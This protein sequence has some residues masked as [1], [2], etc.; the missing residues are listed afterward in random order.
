[1][2]KTKQGGLISLAVVLVVLL[3]LVL[4]PATVVA[5]DGV[6]DRLEDLLERRGGGAPWE[7]EFGKGFGNGVGGGENIAVTGAAQALWCEEVSGDAELKAAPWRDMDGDGLA[8]V[9][10]NTRE[11]L[12]GG[13]YRLTFIAKKGSSG[14]PLWQESHTGPMMEGYA[15]PGADLDGDGGEDVLVNIWEDVGGVNYKTTVIAKNGS[16]GEHLWQENITNAMWG[17]LAFPAGDLDGD[18]K[19]DVMVQYAEDIGGG[20]VKCT[21]IAKRGYDGHHFW[22]EDITGPT[23]VTGMAAYPPKANLDGDGGDDVLVVVAAGINKTLIAKKDFDGHHLWQETFAADSLQMSPWQYTYDLNGDGRPDVVIYGKDVAGNY[24]LAAINGGTGVHL[25]DKTFTGPIDGLHSSRANDL[26]GDGVMD[27]HVI[28]KPT[29]GEFVVKTFSG[30]T[31]Q[32]LWQETVSGATFAD[33]ERSGDLDGDGKADILVDF[34]ED[35]G[36][37]Q[38]RATFIAKKGD[39]GAHL[40]QESITGENAWIYPLGASDLDGD[41]NGDVMVITW[42]GP[43]AGVGR[44]GYIAKKGTNGEHLWEES[45]A[46]VWPSD[47]GYDWYDM[48]DFDCDGL[49]D[50]LVALGQYHAVGSESIIAKKGSTGAHL[51]EVQ[52]DGQFQGW[53]YLAGFVFTGL[54]TYLLEP[55][56]RVE[57]F[58][59]NG[60]GMNDMV[61]WT[62]KKLCAIAPDPCPTPEEAPEVVPPDPEL[63]VSPKVPRPAPACVMIQGLDIC[64]ERTAANQPVT[65][66]TNVVNTGGEAGNYT[67]NLKINGQVEQSR[68]VSVGPGGTYPVKFTVSKAQPGTYTVNIGGQQARFA[69]IGAGGETAGTPVNRGLIVA[70]IIGVLILAT[71]VVLMITFRRPA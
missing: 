2:I 60:D 51:F 18:G 47:W 15:L 58:D 12:G 52:A 17:Y 39:T 7:K 33:V 16:S 42:A 19:G 64:P 32:Q 67:V 57:Y 27:Y 29:G 71:V 45:F 44:Y 43:M 54:G 24:W 26:D 56:Y 20:Q 35:L 4:V 49:R 36:G 10:V 70:L 21:V 38:Y 8:D 55:T 9:V 41:G 37:G 34:Q 6:G 31:G 63:R 69:I 11:D 13:Q 53:I 48:A 23:G 62:G 46:A 1:M 14:T 28:Y 50:M 3:S 68:T 40:W 22:S 65:I 25:W 5:D 59:L 61:V 30:R 66:L